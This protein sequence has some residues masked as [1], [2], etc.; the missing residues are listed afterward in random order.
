MSKQGPFVSPQA[1]RK[2]AIID[3]SNFK[4]QD[5]FTA[6]YE[7][8]FTKEILRSRNTVTISRPVRRKKGFAFKSR[9]MSDVTYEKNRC[10]AILK[11]TRG[12][13]KW[14]KLLAIDRI[15]GGMSNGNLPPCC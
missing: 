1:D 2:L 10:L 4:S 8:F 3:K 14:R 5:T 7:D 9:T 11:E 6:M 12:E 13:A 15:F